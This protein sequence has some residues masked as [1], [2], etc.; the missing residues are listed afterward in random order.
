LSQ[1]EALGSERK[2]QHAKVLAEMDMNLIWASGL[3]LFVA[4]I[5]VMGGSVKSES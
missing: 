5:F 3:M 4:L 1:T 2:V